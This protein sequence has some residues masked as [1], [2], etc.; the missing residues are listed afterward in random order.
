MTP[1]PINGSPTVEIGTGCPTID[2]AIGGGFTTGQTVQ[3]Y[4]EAGAGKT[5]I[6]A[7]T[8]V[9][10][11]AGGNT[12]VFI[13]EDAAAFDRLND[14]AETHPDA[15]TRRTRANLLMQEV[16]GFLEQ[17]EVIRTEVKEA[18]SEAS[19]IVVDG[20]GGHYRRARHDDEI[21]S[22]RAE[23]LFTRQMTFLRMLARRYDIAVIVTNQVYYAP[24]DEE[25]KPLGGAGLQNW[26]DAVL[27]LDAFRN[28][29]HSLLV[30][31]HRDQPEGTRAW[32]TVEERGLDPVQQ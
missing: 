19:V 26:F 3:I 12:A 20:A 21:P 32:F 1:H 16:S 27:R 11:A 17:N 2:D 5:N 7:A 25:L 10:A 13:G 23:E 8:A 28:G 4:G 9:N 18:A 22:D 30:E 31:K 24:D 29:K 15:D 14:L 6:A